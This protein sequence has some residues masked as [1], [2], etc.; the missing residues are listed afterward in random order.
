MPFKRM[1]KFLG[2]IEELQK[3]IS[4]L[5][6]EGEWKE[7]P[8]QV[9]H[10][11]TPEG[12]I[13]DWFHTTKTVRFQGIKAAQEILEDQV[14]KAIS[15]WKPAKK[16]A[17]P[18]VPF[19]SPPVKS[20]GNKRV[21][22]VH[23]HDRVSRDQL[24]LILRRLGLDPFVL[25]NTSGGGLT[26]IEALEKEI[27][28]QPGQC[29][30]GIVLLTPDDVGYVKTEGEGKAAPRARQNVVLEMGMVLSAL[31]R[32]N[33]AIL[34]KG[35]IEIPS[36]VHGIIYIPFNDHVNEAV[37]KLVERLNDAGFN[38]DATAVTRATA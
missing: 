10:F 33:V 25:A 34:K 1:I 35:Y 16:L 32:P 3:L 14:T 4:D 22:V 11:T 19:L 12:A 31:R 28:P 37:P 27:G 20:A 23:G 8:N 13:L 24:E 5:G 29:R 18:G 26:L 17:K 6:C 36:D 9:Y 2:K 7:L 15:E 38:L 21:F 30:F